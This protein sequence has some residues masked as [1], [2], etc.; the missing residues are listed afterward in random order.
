MRFITNCFVAIFAHNDLLVMMLEYI[1]L[2]PLRGAWRLLRKDP[3]AMGEFSF[4]PDA[5]LL[6]FL[7][8]AALIFPLNLYQYNIAVEYL[9]MIVESQ[10]FTELALEQQ[11]QLTPEQQSRLQE[12]TALISESSYLAHLPLLFLSYLVHMGLFAALM[13]PICQFFARA[14]LYIPFIIALHWSWVV[15]TGILTIVFFIA[16]YALYL[17]GLDIAAPIF[18]LLII[19]A[20]ILILVLFLRLIRMILQMSALAAIG[21]MILYLLAY[22]ITYAIFS[23]V[24]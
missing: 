3:Q 18:V 2:A 20:Y 8:T 13:A 21:V 14:N 11:R 7:V 6:S 10:R 22:Q 9:Q 24:L 17:G 19:P 12:L 15:W 23:I 5:F 16:K 4:S 1:L